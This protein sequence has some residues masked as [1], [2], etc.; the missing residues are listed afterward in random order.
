VSNGLHHWTV[1]T[2]LAFLVLLLVLLAAAT[3]LA[4]V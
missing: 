4:A 3:V 1:M 2:A